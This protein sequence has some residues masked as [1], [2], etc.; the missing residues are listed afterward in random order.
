SLADFVV[1]GIGLNAWGTGCSA[2]LTKFSLHHTPQLIVMSAAEDRSAGGGDQAVRGHDTQDVIVVVGS[3]S[4]VGMGDAFGPV[5]K[6]VRISG[7]LGIGVG[8]GSRRGSAGIV[9]LGD[10]LTQ[11]VG[12]GCRKDLGLSAGGAGA[13]A[14][15]IGVVERGLVAERINRGEQ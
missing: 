8:D 2:V 11:G 1:G 12:D 13:V 10:G 14:P 4:T 7:R 15:R 5:H 9:G 6:V 3:A